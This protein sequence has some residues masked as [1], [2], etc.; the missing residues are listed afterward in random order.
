MTSQPD[1]SAN[2]A[3]PAVPVGS[4]PSAAPHQPRAAAG[5][6]KPK[7]RG[8]AP[9]GKAWDGKSGEWI[10]GSGAAGEE[11]SGRQRCVDGAVPA[12]GP[13]D[14]SAAGSFTLHCA[15]LRPPCSVPPTLCFLTAH[16]LLPRYSPSLHILPIFV[17][18]CGLSP[19]THTAPSLYISRSSSC[20][21]LCSF[22]RHLSP[23][24]AGSSQLLGFRSAAQAP[25]PTSWQ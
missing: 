20:A 10:V 22:L 3:Q 8:R 23:F 13:V 15:T 9:K 21:I 5:A 6:L 16:C 24:E 18:P 12:G 14:P 11:T 19:S 4:L 1:A 7:P 2:H 17:N 25:R